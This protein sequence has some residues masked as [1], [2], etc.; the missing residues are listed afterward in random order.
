MP[1]PTSSLMRA[2]AWLML[3]L[4]AVYGISL[5][6]GVRSAPG[7]RADLDWW[8]NMTVDGLVILVLVLRVVADRRDRAAGC[9]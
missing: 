5:V 2:T 1:H 3:A 6:P 7:Y 9:S 8:L 4:G